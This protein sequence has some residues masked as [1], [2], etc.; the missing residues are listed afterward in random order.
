MSA[1]RTG[2][3]KY[4]PNSG[5]AP[6]HAVKVIEVLPYSVL[7]APAGSLTVKYEGGKGSNYVPAWVAEN[8][9]H[10]GGYCVF[11]DHAPGD[12]RVRFESAENIKKNYTQAVPS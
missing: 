6:V 12:M 7:G 1:K 8:A 11:Y 3:P 10:V 9:P 2:F 5:G 4:Q